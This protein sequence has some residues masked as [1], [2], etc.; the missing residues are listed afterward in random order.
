V[1]AFLFTTPSSAE[2]GIGAYNV[3]V[4]YEYVMATGVCSCSLMED[5]YHHTKVFYNLNPATGNHGVIYF[6][7]GSVSWTSPEGLWVAGD[8]DM[9]FCL[10]HG[11]SHDNRGVYLIPYDGVIDEYIVKDG[12]F[13]GQKV[14]NDT[15]VQ[16]Q[17]VVEEQYVEIMMDNKKYKIN[18][19]KLENLK[20]AIS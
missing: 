18:K 17:S 16:A 13:T 12:Y 9:D 14:Q 4:T 20:K 10:Y 19:E 5:R 7:E 6:E 11:K 2:Q 3:K 1:S 15:E 8:T